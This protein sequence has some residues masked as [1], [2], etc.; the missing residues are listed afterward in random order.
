MSSALRGLASTWR[1]ARQ[2]QQ[3]RQGLLFPTQP[4]RSH[5]RQSG[6]AGR[7]RGRLHATLAQALQ[8][9]ACCEVTCNGLWVWISVAAM[10]PTCRQPTTRLVFMRSSSPFQLRCTT[11]SRRIWE[12][13]QTRGPAQGEVRAGSCLLG[14]GT[15]WAFAETGEPSDRPRGFPRQL[16]GAWVPTTLRLQQGSAHRSQF[17]RQTPSKQAGRGETAGPY[18]REPANDAERDARRAHLCQPA[19]LGSVGVAV[20]GAPKLPDLPVVL[21]HPR[22][23]ARGLW[24]AEGRRA[25]VKWGLVHGG[26]CPELLGAAEVRGCAMQ[27]VTAR[28]VCIRAAVVERPPTEY[29]DTTQHTRM[30]NT[31]ILCHTHTHAR[32]LH[33]RAHT[34]TH[35]MKSPATASLIRCRAAM[36]SGL[37]RSIVRGF[38][39]EGRA[40]KR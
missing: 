23:V 40:S 28:A 25:V 39:P 9:A 16:Q 17:Q 19:G 21:Q 22:R 5:R 12:V 8:P 35:T 4:L 6:I 31:H 14:R 33:T 3:S 15:T 30:R 7:H 13:K 36:N 34:H 1:F 18:C 20:P 38:R 10:V 11:R 29:S 2:R 32:T 24:R 26:G 37:A 27:C